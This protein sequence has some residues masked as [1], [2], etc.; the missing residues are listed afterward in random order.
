VYIASETTKA[1]FGQNIILLEISGKIVTN[2]EVLI[3]A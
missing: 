2:I 1:L 3:K